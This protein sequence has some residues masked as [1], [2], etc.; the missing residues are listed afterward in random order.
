MEPPVLERGRAGVV[1]PVQCALP[2][3]AAAAALD[4]GG[5]VRGRGPVAAARAGSGVSVCATVA[6]AVGVCAAAPVAHLVGGRPAALRAQAKL[7]RNDERKVCINLDFL[8]VVPHVLS[9]YDMAP[10]EG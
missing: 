3:P 1:P 5:A 2:V 4:Q 7:R 8:K 10:W 6:A 9:V